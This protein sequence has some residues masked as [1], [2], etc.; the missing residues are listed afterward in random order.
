MICSDIVKAYHFRFTFH[1]FN[2]HFGAFKQTNK[3][4][5]CICIYYRRFSMAYC[6]HYT[7]SS[8]SFLDGTTFRY[9]GGRKCER[10]K[11]CMSS[12]KPAGQKIVNMA[13]V[14]YF[15]VNEEITVTTMKLDNLIA[16][17]TLLERT[18]R[19]YEWEIYCLFIKI[20]S[21]GSLHLLFVGNIYYKQTLAFISNMVRIPA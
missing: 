8:S 2:Y 1:Y 11:M 21:I 3:Q 15:N 19:K 16:A 7:I 14:I 6:T 18:N 20:I 9:L 5:R 17:V 10:M 13:P 4:Q 12:I